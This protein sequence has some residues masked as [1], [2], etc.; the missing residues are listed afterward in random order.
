MEKE[1]LSAAANSALT[2]DLSKKRRKDKAGSERGAASG[3]KAVKKGDGCSL[4]TLKTPVLKEGGIVRSI[5][6]SGRLRL[7]AR[8]TRY[9]L[10][11]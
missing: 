8:G 5:L 11:L 10:M 3:R 4:A 7:L 9:E 6:A 1:E 2:A